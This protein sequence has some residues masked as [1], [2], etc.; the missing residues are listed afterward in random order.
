MGTGADTNNKD[1]NK[2][3]RTTNVVSVVT[4]SLSF[5]IGIFLYILSKSE[6]I[7]YP[8]LIETALFGAVILLNFLRQYFLAALLS[9]FIQCMATLCF[10]ILL[11]KI[12]D[13]QLM[14]V[15]LV[16]T[17]LLLFREKNI[18]IVC[19]LL[20]CLTMFLLEVNNYTY[21]VE[22]V[23]INTD[24][25]VL[26]RSLSIAT[27][28]FLNGMVLFY[29]ERNSRSL[30]LQLQQT[31]RDLEQV[32]AS[33]SVYVRE[34]THELRAPLNAIHGIS[35]FL[36]EGKYSPADL[37]KYHRGIYH[38]SHMALEIINNV[39][40]LA[41]IESGNVHEPTL[42]K[43]NIRNWLADTTAIFSQHA[44]LKQVSVVTTVGD[45]VPEILVFDPIRVMQ[46]LNNLI[47]N[48]IKFSFPK[49][50]IFVDI[51]SGDGQWT[52]AVRDQGVG[53]NEDQVR[54]IFDAFYSTRPSNEYGTGLGLHIA[55]NLAILLG[56]NI[57]ADS[58]PGKGTVFTTTLP[59]PAT[60]APEK[61]ELPA[62]R[63]PI[64][65]GA[66]VI[67]I[68]DD[69]MSAELLAKYLGSIGAKTTVCLTGGEGFERA[70]ESKPDLI[71][72]DM[73][74][75]DTRGLVLLEKFK[76]D[77]QLKRIPVIII[78]G[79]VFKEDQDEA[80]R[81]GAAGFLAKPVL[82]PKVQAM[83]S[84]VLHVAGH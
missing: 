72:M 12:I 44:A 76:R 18:R 71:L 46:I 82:F 52:L 41:K 34:T 8:A 25:H 60:T 21:F 5:F 49:G 67:I 20:T 14:A 6:L 45:E 53:M 66:S 48:A 59:L 10:G 26:F 56:G 27:I 19:I 37:P 61:E 31:N 62:A 78:S 3:I 38:S 15:F 7:L 32:S 80:A 22:P 63:L 9:H 58:E 64:P 33:K 81:R 35:Q 16:G 73:D 43:I 70:S 74:L 42:K 11:G 69:R 84:Q 55:Q 2:R 83:I 47:T 4:G 50:Q 1:L 54:R 77:A 79:S 29:Y 30:V 57:V 40:E 36:Y 23:A 65:P 13:A 39:M 28:L 51:G 24:L 68:D 17:P 75:P